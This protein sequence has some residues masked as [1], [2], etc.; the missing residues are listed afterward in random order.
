M[1]L[2]VPERRVSQSQ[3]LRIRGPRL[4]LHHLWPHALSVSGGLRSTCS[5]L[6]APKDRRSVALVPASSCSWRLAGCD[7]QG[8][9]QWQTRRAA[10]PLYA[11]TCANSQVSLPMACLRSRSARRRMTRASSTSSSCVL[12]HPLFSRGLTI[13]LQS[14][15]WQ[16]STPSGT[17]VTR[18]LFGTASN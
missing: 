16:G 2:A 12:C 11:V 1:H 13:T 6:P 9:V 17:G 5:R 15:Y 10:G 3:D 7:F 8:A 18:L 14:V 4:E